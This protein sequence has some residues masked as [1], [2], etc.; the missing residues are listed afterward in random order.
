VPIGL[1]VACI[2]IIVVARQYRR[3]RLTGPAR[4]GE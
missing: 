4:D 2:G 3:K 1:L